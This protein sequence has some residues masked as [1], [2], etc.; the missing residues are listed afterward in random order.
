MHNDSPYKVPIPERFFSDAEGK[1]FEVCHVCGKSLLQPGINYVVE[2]AM[3][4]YIGYDFSSTIYELAICTDCHQKVQKGM[5]EESMR[6]LQNYYQSMM[7]AKG[8]Q[9]MYIDLRTFNLNDWLSK[10]FFK[11]GNIS[12]M[13]EYQ[14]VA[15][16]EGD[17]MIM[18]TPPMII[19]TEAMNEMAELMSDKTIG[20]MNDFRQRFM[21][22]SPELEELIYGKKLIML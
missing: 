12:E 2:K 11:G 5:S 13:E 21:G 10:C 19:G 14:V 9:P 1:P 3:K 15:Q 8:N 20:D 18:N 6:N 4:N 7:A 16:F 22:P 17:K